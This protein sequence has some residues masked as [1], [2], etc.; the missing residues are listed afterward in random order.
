VE[1]LADR[2]VACPPVSHAGALALL[3]QLRIR[4]LLAGWRSSPP[5]DIDALADVIVAFSRMALELGDIVEAVEA[6]PVIAT[7]D[8]VV[9]VDALIQ[10]R[11]AES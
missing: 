1:L 9:A 3:D 8:G 6:N 7:A 5:V 4:A 10:M 2:A 11:R